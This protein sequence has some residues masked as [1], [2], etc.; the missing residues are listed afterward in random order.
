MIKAD[1]VSVKFG[2]V[3]PLDAVSAEFHDGSIFGL[4]GSN[5]SGKSTLL[6]VM[7]GIVKPDCGSLTYNGISVWENDLV[8][9]GIIY[10]SDEQYFMPHCSINDMKQLYKSLCTA[11]SEDTFK[12]L[13]DIFKLDCDRKIATFSKGMKKQASIMLGISA[14]PKYLLC[15]ETFDGL[16]PV[17]R[18]LVKRILAE[19]SAERQMT[20]IIASHNLREIEDICD[21]IGLLHKGELLF[22]RELD[23]MKL[24]L[25]KVQAIFDENFDADQLRPLHILRYERRGSLVTFVVRGQEGEI[26]EFLRAKSPTFFETIPLTLEEIFISEMEEK[27]YDFGKLI[28]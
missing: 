12:K 17:V 16:D 11:F 20:T 23:D 18:H 7:A 3:K 9:Q 13:R 25:H 4:I 10:L 2:A 14:R 24:G 1:N 27:G 19:E 28:Y 6:R 26:N 21:T 15:D 5:G 8:K 22:V